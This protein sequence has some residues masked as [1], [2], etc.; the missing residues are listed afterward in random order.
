MSEDI[1]IF[2]EYA[3]L[4][5]PHLEL[6]S[7]RPGELAR[8]SRLTDICLDERGKPVVQPPETVLGTW[9]CITRIVVSIGEGSRP[10]ALDVRGE[11]GLNQVAVGGGP[12]MLTN[13]RLVGAVSTGNSFWG[14]LDDRGSLVWEYDLRSIDFLSLEVMSGLLGTK[15]KPVVVTT[16]APMTNVVLEVFGHLDEN[17]TLIRN[18]S[19]RSL[20]ETLSRATAALQLKE[21][22]PSAD[23]RIRLEKAVSGE[24]E[25]DGDENEWFVDLLGD[26]GPT[27]D[28]S[29]LR[30]D[31]PHWT[32]REVASPREELTMPPPTATTI[33]TSVTASG[34]NDPP[35]SKPA[36][37]LPNPSAGPADW[38]GSA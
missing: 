27:I 3:H 14:D 20:M 5:L 35:D 9:L 4:A 21:S 34:D 8:A 2:L 11:F 19:S 16:M 13:R 10:S 33:D 25:W 30:T 15:E 24:L 37:P 38:W 7:P 31:R 1:D 22:E 17:D 26:D 36:R 32:G 18:K 6:V 29:G 28:D 23:T 12:A